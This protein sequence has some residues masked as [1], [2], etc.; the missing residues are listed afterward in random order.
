MRSLGE[1]Y[2]GH[3]EWTIVPVFFLTLVTETTAE[4]VCIVCKDG[5]SARPNEIVLCDKCGVGKCL[6]LG[7]KLVFI[8]NLRSFILIG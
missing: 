8:Q 6:E 1:E 3:S 4:I 2:F 7:N 5:A